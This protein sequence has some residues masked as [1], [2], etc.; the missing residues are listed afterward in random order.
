MALG[1]RSSSGYRSASRAKHHPGSGPLTSNVRATHGAV[2]ANTVVAFRFSPQTSEHHV[3]SARARMPSRC[4]EP[5][6]Q[7][8]GESSALLR[9]QIQSSC[10][11]FVADFGFFGFGPP[12]L[13]R[14]AHQPLFAQSSSQRGSLRLGCPRASSQYRLLQ[15]RTSV[16]S[17]QEQTPSSGW[18]CAGAS[19]VGGQLHSHHRAVTPTPNAP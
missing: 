1:P 2:W 9:W 17:W 11:R 16:A 8:R 5:H 14:A 3:S 10:W 12:V 15:L 7:A 4:R 19:L 18:G 13:R 6:A